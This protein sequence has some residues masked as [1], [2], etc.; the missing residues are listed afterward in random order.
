MRYYR[1]YFEKLYRLDLNYI[2]N[3]FE[4]LGE[5]ISRK[6]YAIDDNLVM[7]I[8]K[9]IEG[10]YQNKVE[11][12]VFKNAGDQYSKYIC[13]IVWF[14]PDF[15]IMPRAV[16]LSAYTRSKKVNLKAIR[17]EAEAYNDILNFTQKF[18]MLPEDIEATSS[19]GLV[20]S[21]P[22]L[23]DYGCTSEKGDRFYDML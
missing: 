8:S 23:I 21:V 1:K 12:Y 2:E 7:K 6:V 13:P 3:N 9:G 5:G 4:Y 15:L 16:P 11:H 22:V 17:S 18:Y 10:L 19:W 20:N 14:R